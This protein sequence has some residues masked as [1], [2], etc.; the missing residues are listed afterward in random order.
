MLLNA[1]PSLAGTLPP[2]T[3]RSSRLVY[4][5]FP[6]LCQVLVLCVRSSRPYFPHII[7]SIILFIPGSLCIPWFFFSYRGKLFDP[8]TI[9]T[10]EET[11]GLWTRYRAFNVSPIFLTCLILHVKLADLSSSASRILSVSDSVLKLLYLRQKEGC[12]CMY[13]SSS[14]EICSGTSYLWSLVSSPSLSV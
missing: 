13:F 5:P 9:T 2:L 4:C 3:G 10:V 6:F 14:C 11:S 7:I 8:L 1:A 12:I